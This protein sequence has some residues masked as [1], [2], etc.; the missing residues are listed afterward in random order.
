[1]QMEMV[2]VWIAPLAATQVPQDH[3]LVLFVPM[4]ATH[5]AQDHRLAKMSQMVTTAKS[6]V[7][8]LPAAPRHQSLAQ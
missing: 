2:I 6:V 1:M 8:M 4:A 3:L 5:L 7:V